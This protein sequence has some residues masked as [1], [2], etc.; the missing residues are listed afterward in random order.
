MMQGV[1]EQP[2]KDEGEDP[3]SR[4]GLDQEGKARGEDPRLLTSKKNYLYLR[5]KPHDPD[6]PET[7]PGFGYWFIGDQLV[8]HLILTIH[9]AV[10]PF[11]LQKESC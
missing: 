11:F 3:L 10:H 5:E 6:F 9:V 1:E 2:I 4:A 8:L 7:L